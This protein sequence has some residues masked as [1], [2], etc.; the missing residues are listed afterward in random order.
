M[1]A[2]MGGAFRYLKRVAELQLSRPLG[3]GGVSQDVPSASIGMSERHWSR[4]A[5]RALLASLAGE[6]GANAGPPLSSLVAACDQE[7]LVSLALSEG[8]AGPA[9]DKLGP[10][11]AP[12]ARTKTAYSGATACCPPPGSVGVVATVR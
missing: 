3:Q 11:L 4:S 1:P 12:S 10:L 9:I 7:E 8:V 6:Y 5:R 2:A